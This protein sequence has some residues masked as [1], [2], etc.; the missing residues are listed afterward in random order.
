MLEI[1]FPVHKKMLGLHFCS[2]CFVGVRVDIERRPSIPAVKHLVALSRFSFSGSREG[3]RNDIF[4]AINKIPT[5]QFFLMYFTHT[6]STIS[7]VLSNDR[8]MFCIL[9]D[10][11]LNTWNDVVCYG[12]IYYVFSLDFCALL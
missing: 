6:K 3:C 8:V 5:M 2:T 1:D 11:Y 9:I 10:F 7:Y 4:Y 12:D